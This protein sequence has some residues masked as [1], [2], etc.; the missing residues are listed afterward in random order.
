MRAERRWTWIF[1][2]AV[3]RIFSQSGL[4]MRPNKPKMSGSLMEH[5]AFS[6]W[7]STVAGL[8]FRSDS[9]YTYCVV[10]LSLWLS[11]CLVWRINVFIIIISI[12]N[13]LILVTH[14]I[15]N[16]A[17]VL[18]AYNKCIIMNALWT[19]RFLLNTLWL[20]FCLLC[21]NSIHIHN[22]HCYVC[23]VKNDR[24]R[25]Q[26]YIHLYHYFPNFYA[27]SAFHPYGAHEVFAIQARLSLLLL[28]FEVNKWVVSC[29]RMCA[30]SLGWRHLVNAYLRKGRMV[31]SIRG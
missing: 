12:K 27:N 31:H 4:L 15:R 22:G 13:E 26:K 7:Q 19:L 16:I 9:I 5:M 28:L 1:T 21:V 2:A 23:Y 8:S 29:N 25:Q 20:L 11:F 14:N 30:A 10:N 3:E 24:N 18:S 17:R 6:K